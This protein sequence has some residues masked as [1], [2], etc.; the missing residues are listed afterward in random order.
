MA[1]IGGRALLCTSQRKPA[2]SPAAFLMRHC[3]PPLLLTQIFRGTVAEAAAW[4]VERPPKGEFTVVL[5]AAD[6]P[7]PEDEAAAAV[8]GIDAALGEVGL[9]GALGAGVAGE[10]HE[11]GGPSFGARG[12]QLRGG[13]AVVAAVCVVVLNCAPPN[14]GVGGGGGSGSG[15]G[16][17]R[18]PRG[19]RGRAR[20]RSRAPGEPQGA[21]PQSRGRERGGG[22]EANNRTAG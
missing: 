3:A 7:T 17:G 12:P 5:A 21:L 11:A 13:G 2:Q 4:L 14:G 1:K 20:G 19:L 9:H 15:I 6:P 16:G 8:A 18:Q 22:G 10:G